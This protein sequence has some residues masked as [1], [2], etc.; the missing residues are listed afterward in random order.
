MRERVS[1]R[2]QVK[3]PFPRLSVIVWVSNPAMKG[4][5]HPVT[6]SKTIPLSHVP[7]FFPPPFHP[8]IH[9][10]PPST[11]LP[12]ARPHPCKPNHPP[13][14]NHP[15]LTA[16]ICC[17]CASLLRSNSMHRAAQYKDLQCCR[18]LRLCTAH[19]SPRWA[20]MAVDEVR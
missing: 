11:A 2:R 16:P 7:Q 6:P 13:P 20:R 14:I 1:R 5:R 4:N 19:H 10:I 15:P 17:R 18:R 12:T 3:E 9:P 8:I